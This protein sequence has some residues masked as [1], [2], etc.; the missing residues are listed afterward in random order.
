MKDIW[1]LYSLQSLTL[2]FA[3]IAIQSLIII[4]IIIRGI[5]VLKLLKE[6]VPSKGLKL[7]Y[8]VQ[9]IFLHPVAIKSGRISEY[10]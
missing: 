7:A 1:E 10:I 6:K 5:S 9:E 8:I 2:F 3:S 4:N